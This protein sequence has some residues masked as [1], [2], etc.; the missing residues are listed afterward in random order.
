MAVARRQQDHDELQV[1]VRQNVVDSL[2]NQG[3]DDLVEMLMQL[4]NDHDGMLQSSEAPP[5]FDGRLFGLLDANHDGGLQ[6]NELKSLIKLRELSLRR[7]ES[8]SPKR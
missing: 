7:N 6:P 2:V 5:R 1:S 8:T 3:T 4:D